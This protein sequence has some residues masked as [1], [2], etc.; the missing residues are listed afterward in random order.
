MKFKLESDQIENFG[1][2][3]TLWSEATKKIER[4]QRLMYESLGQ[5]VANMILGQGTYKINQIEHKLGGDSFAKFMAER[6]AIDAEATPNGFILSV[7]G[8]TE[9]QVGSGKD[10]GGKDYNLWSFY[11]MGG[12]IAERTASSGLNIQKDAGSVA[13]IKKRA[14]SFRVDGRKG[15]VSAVING[16]MPRIERMATAALKRY[17]KDKIV[18]AGNDAAK[19]AKIKGLNL[20]APHGADEMRLPKTVVEIVE[21]AVDGRGVR[22]P[23]GR[24]AKGQFTSLG[25]NVRKKIG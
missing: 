8:L 24:N 2:M 1:Q 13:V 21:G 23:V 11:E 19:R 7:Y 25:K 12:E 22:I 16:L 20:L 15:A 9:S 6:T 4:D 10:R 17:A 14:N 18:K 5:D 3:L